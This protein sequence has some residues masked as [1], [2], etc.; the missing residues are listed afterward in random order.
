M[1][2]ISL[3]EVERDRLYNTAVVVERGVLIGRYRKTRL[4][5]GEAIFT[6]GADSPIFEAGGLR[7]GINICYGGRPP[8]SISRAR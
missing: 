4:L 2:P 1:V 5:R 8:S 6:P 7:F 3:I